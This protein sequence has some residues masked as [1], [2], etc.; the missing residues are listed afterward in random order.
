MIGPVSLFEQI[1]LSELKGVELLIGAVRSHQFFMGASFRNASVY[2]YGNFVCIADGG[3]T[4]CYYQSSTS[5]AQL[6]QGLLN[7]YFGGVVQG[8]GGFVQD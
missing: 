5:L 7:E 3:E 4:M 8:A 1:V 2:D 6:V